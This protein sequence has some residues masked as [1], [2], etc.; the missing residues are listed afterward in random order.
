[1]NILKNSG[2]EWIGNIPSEW[3]INKIKNVAKAS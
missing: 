1:M 3:E 2:I